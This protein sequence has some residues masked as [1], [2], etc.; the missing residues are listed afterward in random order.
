MTEEQ[1]AL[2]TSINDLNENLQ[3]KLASFSPSDRTLRFEREETDSDGQVW[4]YTTFEFNCES[5]TLECYDE[6]GDLYKMTRNELMQCLEFI[7]S[8]GWN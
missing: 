5:E 4:G 1:I 7:E 2:L 3:T 8:L 6:N